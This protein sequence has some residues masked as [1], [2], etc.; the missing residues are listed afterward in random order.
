MRRFGDENVYPAATVSVGISDM[1]MS[2]LNCS[3]GPAAQATAAKGVLGA[4]NYKRISLM[5]PPISHGFRRKEG[6]SD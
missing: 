5:H 6:D 2:L 3:I 4:G 1:V